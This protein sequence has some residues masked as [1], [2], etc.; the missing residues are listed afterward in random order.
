MSLSISYF[1]RIRFF[2]SGYLCVVGVNL[3]TY[4]VTSKQNE[5]GDTMLLV[6]H[7]KLLIF[8]FPLELTG[9]QKHRVIDKGSFQV[10]SNSQLINRVSRLCFQVQSYLGHPCHR[11][12]LEMNYIF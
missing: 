6:T 4:N 7:I 12:K 11:S 9:F 8:L 1:V 5:P 10:S 2:T 3:E